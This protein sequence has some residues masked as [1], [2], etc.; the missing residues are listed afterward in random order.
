MVR[1]ILL[2]YFFSTA[3]LGQNQAHLDSLDVALESAQSSENKAKIYSKLIEGYLTQDLVK[4]LAYAE[5]L[6]QFAIKEND[7]ELLDRALRNIYNTCV[8]A[9]D[10][11]KAEQTLQELQSLYNKT[12]N[13]KTQNVILSGKARLFL[14][15]AEYKNAI[16][17]YQEAIAFNIANIK[18]DTDYELYLAGN[19]LNYAITLMSWA[20]I[21]KASETL[22]IKE[23][24]KL[25]KQC[26]NLMKQSLAFRE[27]END[28]TEATLVYNNLAV[29][30]RVFPNNDSVL[31]Y[32]KR[33]LDLAKTNNDSQKTAIAYTSLAT[34]YYGESQFSKSI[35]Y[36]NKALTIYQ[37]LGD[38]KQIGNVLCEKAKNYIW[39]EQ[40]DEAIIDLE[41]ANIL[42]EK[43]SYKQGVMMVEELLRDAYE[44]KKDFEKAYHHYQNYVALRTE[45]LSEKNMKDIAW[46][47]AKYDSENRERKIVELDNANLEK[48]KKIKKNFYTILLLIATIII[49]V[50]LVILL[51]MRNKNKKKKHEIEKQEMLTQLKEGELKST[52]KLMEIKEIT[53]QKIAYELHDRLGVMLATIKLY[54]G[55]E[56]GKLENENS[57]NNLGKSI[58]L[59]Q[60]SIDEVRAISSELASPTLERFGINTAIEELVQNINQVGNIK[61]V[62]EYDDEISLD[63]QL[64]IDIYR[65]VQELLSNAIKHSK[66]NT[67]NL[68]LKTEDQTIKLYY[69]D[70]G[71][72]LSEIETK[73]K[74]NIGWKSIYNRINQQKGTV[75]F[76]LSKEG[77]SVVFIFPKKT[78]N[79]INHVI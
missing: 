19:R 38:Q 29:L 4:A 56:E 75:E 65:I 74:Q 22:S 28:I 79:P 48:E 27:R 8:L 7:D 57:K 35:D 9:G 50:L 1:Y 51:I 21:K 78:N 6:K 76:L 53:K 73:E 55:V 67:I 63:S 5:Q 59:L 13:P 23:E 64:K 36:L 16:E 44:E 70:N 2:L 52:L 3:L 72:G 34:F 62:Y 31:Y 12:Q 11:E 32:S 26:L 10:L 25:K 39:T 58:D 77:M 15:K 68:K 37:H 30:Y 49:V 40:Y 18:N 66:A 61:V 45:I 60:K 41:K 46:V 24:E 20:H 71:V 47:R 33:A 69:S 14:E 43:V 42:F 54:V 17:I